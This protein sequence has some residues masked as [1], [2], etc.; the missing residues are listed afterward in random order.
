MHDFP[1]IIK[2]IASE[3]P[4]GSFHKILSA[5]IVQEYDILRE[6]IEIFSTSSK[7]YTIRGMHF[8]RYPFE[9]G[10]LVWVTNGSILDY[11]VDIRKMKTFGQVHQF[12]LTAKSHE[13]LWVPPGFAHGFQALEDNSI[14]NYATDGPYNVDADTGIHWNS[15]GASWVTTPSNVSMRDSEFCTLREYKTR[16]GM[17]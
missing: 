5:E 13:S 10:K 8:Q 4:R 16:I 11:V 6:T 15:F 2:T 3:D 14:L 9:T 1:T 17:T 12:T 7:E